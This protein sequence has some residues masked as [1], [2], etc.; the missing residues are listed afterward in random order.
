LYGIGMHLA[1]ADSNSD[2]F[3]SNR[4]NLFV[5]VNQGGTLVR[6]SNGGSEITGG[7]TVARFSPPSTGSGNTWVAAQID[8]SNGE[9]TEINKVLDID[10][11]SDI[12]LQGFSELTE[13]ANRIDT[14]QSI[15]NETLDVTIGALLEF[16]WSSSSLIDLDAHLNGPSTSSSAP[17]F[18][19]FF[20]DTGGSIEGAEHIN[21]CT[22]SCKSEV[23][24]INSFNQ[25]SLY[26]ASLHNFTERNSTTSTSFSDNR[27]D[28]FFK[29]TQGGSIQRGSNGSA[30]IT[31]G[32]DIIKLS[33]PS[34]GVGNTWIAANID[35]STGQVQIVNKVV[36]FANSSSVT[37]VVSE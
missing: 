28:I 36:N 4:E 32:T 10:G 34:S 26:R 20:G 30:I 24:S 17:I 18:H 21:D 9:I 19:V 31:G 22:G 13:L 7:T 12:N 15:V 3:V 14:I 27:E 33:P 37:G 35:P 1:S 23:I 6:T 29:I 16:N 11:Q 8:A 25:G 5:R 2:A